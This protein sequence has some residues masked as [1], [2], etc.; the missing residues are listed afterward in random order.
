MNGKHVLLILA[1]LFRKKGGSIAID[2][3][4]EYL[5]FRCRYGTPSNI[6]RLLFLGLQNEMISKDNDL[7]NAE[8]LYDKQEISPNIIQILHEKVFLDKNVEELL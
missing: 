1:H 6:R 4:V 3:A 7:I 8:F 5:S 2:N